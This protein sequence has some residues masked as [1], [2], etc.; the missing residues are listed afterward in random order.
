MTYWRMVNFGFLSQNDLN[1]PFDCKY[2]LS[3]NYASKLFERTS[4]R[5][6]DDLR[7]SKQSI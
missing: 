7:K 1:D 6:L 3:E 5:M 2:S 4:N